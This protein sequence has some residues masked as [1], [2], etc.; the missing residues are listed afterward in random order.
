MLLCEHGFAYLGKCIAV[1]R[2]HRVRAEVQ[3]VTYL[4]E[5]QFTPYMQNHDLALITWKSL[6]R[7]SQVLFSRIVSV[8]RAEPRRIWVKRRISVPKLAVVERG[9]SHARK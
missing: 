6:Q 4:R 2:C 7:A 3:Q 9:V 8:G 1:S 5:G